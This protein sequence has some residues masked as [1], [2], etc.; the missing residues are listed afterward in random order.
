MNLF[1]VFQTAKR[2]FFDQ[3]LWVRTF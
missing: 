3:G 2:Y 1:F